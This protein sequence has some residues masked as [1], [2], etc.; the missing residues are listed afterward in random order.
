[1]RLELPLPIQQ[2]DSVRLHMQQLIGPCLVLLLLTMP[3]WLHSAHNA[4]APD[5]DVVARSAWT[6][7]MAESLPAHAPSTVDC[8]LH[9]APQL[10]VPTLLLSALLLPLARPLLPP[11]ARFHARLGSAPPLPPPRT[12]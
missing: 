6:A 1:M 2:M 10:L 5:A 8:A 3:L 12:R 7:E 4:G 11:L 9:C